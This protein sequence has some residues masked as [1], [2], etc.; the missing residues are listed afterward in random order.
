M[1]SRG[2]ICHGGHGRIDVLVNNAGI[3]IGGSVLDFEL[4]DWRDRWRS[5]STVCS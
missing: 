4:S 5:M 3:G 1:E 2:D